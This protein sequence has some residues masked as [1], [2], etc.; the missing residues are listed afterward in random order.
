MTG[1]AHADVVVLMEEP[2]GEFGHINP[3]GHAAVYFDRLCASTPTQLRLCAQ[4]EHGVVVSRY[5]RVAGFDWLAIPPLPYF[6]AVKDRSQIPA[7]ADRATRDD[8]R[9]AYRR[10]ELEGLI[11]DGMEGGSSRTPKGN[12][13]QLIGSSYD[14]RIYGF[15]IHTEAGQDTEL[16]NRLNDHANVD[17]FNLFTR[18]C[19]D[20]TRGIV[21]FYYPHALHRSFVIDFGITTPKEDAKR[22]LRFAK[23]HPEIPFASFVIPQV[24]GTIPRSRRIDNVAEALVRSKKYVIP[25]ALL[26]PEFTVALIGDV[27]AG[28]RHS[29]WPTNSLQL[30]DDGQ[31]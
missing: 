22:L 27:F 18:N 2:Y 14:R 11:P 17:H 31:I 3:T 30:P 26:E 23:R 13:T 19:A 12:W 25:L 15:R 1:C 8:L 10:E 6:Y 24:P 7:E 21:N 29:F 20:F 4:D 5:H 16:M 9:D 28:D